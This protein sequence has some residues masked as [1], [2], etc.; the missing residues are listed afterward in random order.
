MGEQVMK[1]FLVALVLAVPTLALALGTETTPQANVKDSEFVAGKKAVEDRNWQVAIRAF[2]Q[3]VKGDPRNA[4]AH[5]YLG[6]SYR[7]AG[8]MDLSFKHYNEALRLDPNHRGANEYIG[9]A[10]LKTNKPAQAEEH[11]ARLERICGK[12]CDEY[13][14][15]GKGIADYKAKNK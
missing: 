15:L 9:W 12:S 7:N 8:Q 14:K 13:Q 1:N 4:D 10:Y 3:A 2:N 11:L 5:N 6:Y